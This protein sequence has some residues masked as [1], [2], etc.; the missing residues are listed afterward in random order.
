M[1]SLIKKENIEKAIR[2]CKKNG[3]KDTFYASMEKLYPS[4]EEKEIYIAPD[5]ATCKIQR[6][7]K[8][9]KQ[10]KFSILVPAYETKIPY[11]EKLL[12]SVLS[13]TYENWELIIADASSSFILKDKIEEYKDHRIIYLKLSENCGISENTN[14][15]LEKV[16]GDYVALLDHDDF[17]SPDALYEM[18]LELEKSEE[19]GIEKLLL[20]SDEDKCNSE[21]TE[22]YEVHKKEK[23][24][25]DLILSNNYFCHLLVIQTQL[26]KRLKFRR[27]YDGAQDYDLV[28]R[29][30][31]SILPQEERIG[32]V[33]KILYHWRCHEDSTAANTDSKMYAY[34]AGR[35]A[36][37][38][39]M[40]QMN[41]EGTVS[42]SKHLG[43]Y[44]IT[45]IP[46]LM[47][48]RKNVG[49]VGGALLN[50]Q[51]KI[52]G[53]I[54]DRFGDPLYRGLHKEFSGYMHRASLRQEADIVDIRIMKINPDLVDIVLDILGKDVLV[55]EDGRLNTLMLPEDTNYMRL[56]KSVC[57][58]IKEAG[59]HIIWDPCWK[60]K[61]K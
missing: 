10:V 61:I 49:A 12:D 46:D 32:H 36:L 41:W 29:A 9:K 52:T 7:K 16:T 8:W 27:E 51:N 31:A 48:V 30:I 60:E 34:E 24:N 45:F 20:Y 39:F 42:N 44:R 22:F 37:E 35:R 13:Q 11:F 4:K 58:A 57:R 15:G 21:G 19:K 50:G 55:E 2:Y 6:E 25:L 47:S 56:N 5:E 26:L 40:V 3:I 18:A 33:G 38:D 43:F 59:Y 14:K 28:L 1:T 54:Y 17:L 53:G 23:F